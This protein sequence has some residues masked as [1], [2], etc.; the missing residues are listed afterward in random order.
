MPSR[1]VIDAATRMYHWLF[2]LSFLG[3]YLTAEG[4]RWRMLHVTLGYTL[5]GLLVFR[6]V[7]GLLAPGRPDCRP[8]GPSEP[9]WGRLAAQRLWRARALASVNW[10]QGQNLLMALAVVCMLVAVVPVTLTKGYASF[11]GGAPTP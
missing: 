11:N 6:V 7:Y 3:A 4:R 10:R 1:R 9:R 8:C 5:A 2:A